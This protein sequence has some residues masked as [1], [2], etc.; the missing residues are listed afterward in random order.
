MDSMQRS[1][2]K[3]VLKIDGRPTC[4]CCPPCI[5]LPPGTKVGLPNLP[6]PTASALT[7]ECPRILILAGGQLLA[8]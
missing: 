7:G 5:S 1:E 8:W 4:S 2:A 6:R 3:T